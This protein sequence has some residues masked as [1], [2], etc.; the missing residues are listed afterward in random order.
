MT[1]PREVKPAQHKGYLASAICLALACL[2][3]LVPSA[4]WAAA[5][6]PSWQLGLRSTGY[7]YQ[8]EDAAGATDDQFRTFNVISGAATGLANGKLAFRGAGR[9]AN[10]PML[11]T[12]GF[13]KSRL[14]S[15]HLEARVSPFVKARVGRQFIQSGVTSM[16][17]DGA[18]LS[19]R[20]SGGLD[21][22]LWGGARAPLA[23]DFELGKLD[24]AAAV[25][26]RVALRPH[27]KWRVAVSSA[28]RER[29]GRVAER[30]LGMDLN[31]SAVRN[32]RL[33]GRVAYDLEQE[34]WSRLQ[35]QARWRPSSRSPVVTFQY[36]DRHP[37][38][39]AAS[40]FARF[41][42]VA[43][44]RLARASVRYETP[45]R[46]G[47]EVNYVGSFVNDRMSS[48]VGL[49]ALVPGG[50][51]GYSARLGDA[52]EESR[53]Y[54][55]LAGQVTSWL[56]LDGQAT[57]LTYA[58]FADAPADQERDLT[59]F[60]LRARANLRRGLRATVEIQSLDNP[61]FSKD[62]RLLVGV[63]LAMARGASRYGLDRGGWLR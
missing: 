3:V 11:V 51:V 56:E 12:S 14:Y 19:Y 60:S 18:W 8:T 21:A 41:T 44:I 33:F 62:V 52:G 59:M 46:F 54:G 36:I 42:D 35:A 4:T 47:G 16:T 26:G 63:D 40:W 55:E 22:S 37:S 24:A 43:R 6:P 17:L 50:R 57:F 49:A 15:G 30:P 27:R 38:I 39:D 25:G 32:T 53:I 48:R 9:F 2:I 45:A 29:H 1:D 31:T 58:L 13:A 7:F 20:K 34:R 28:Y 23:H 61:L 10:E 5:A